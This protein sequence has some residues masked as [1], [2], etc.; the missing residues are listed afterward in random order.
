MKSDGSVCSL[1]LLSKSR[2]RGR[3]QEMF[4]NKNRRKVVLGRTNQTKGQDNR[5]MKHF[6]HNAAL[7]PE[8]TAR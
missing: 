4:W 8:V 3:G 6:F 2:N 7:F 5:C 1:Q